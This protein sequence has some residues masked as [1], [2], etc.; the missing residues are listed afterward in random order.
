MSA[1]L[2]EIIVTESDYERLAAILDSRRSGDP[3]ASSLRAE[4]DRADV[5]ESTEVPGDLVTMNS[6]VVLEDPET[7]ERFDVTLVYPSAADFDAGRLSVLAPVGAALLGLRVDQ[8]IDWP[9]PNGRVRTIR[10]VSVDW[11]PEAAG[12]YDR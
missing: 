11:Q 9:L 12:E 2:P 8:T 10:V 1:I 6:R 7:T 5:V 4:I 3:L